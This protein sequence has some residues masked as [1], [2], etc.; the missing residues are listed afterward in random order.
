MNIYKMEKIC[1]KNNTLLTVGLISIPIITVPVI[2]SNKEKEN[3]DKFKVT[4]NQ[5]EE[6]SIILDNISLDLNNVVENTKIKFTVKAKDGFKAIV[7]N[8]ET[9]LNAENGK[10]TVVVSQATTISVEYNFDY[11]NLD[12]SNLLVNYSKDGA[13]ETQVKFADV[14]IEKDNFI[15]SL[16]GFNVNVKNIEK[17][18]TKILLTYTLTKEGLT[19][20]SQ[21]FTKE[22]SSNFFGEKINVVEN[23]LNE[24]KNAIESD[25]LETIENKKNL[26]AEALE[27]LFNEE[28]RNTYLTTS[29]E[30]DKKYDFLKFIVQIEGR[31]TVGKDTAFKPEP[32]HKMLKLFN[33]HWNGNK[34]QALELIPVFIQTI[35]H[36]EE[37]FQN[38]VT[39]VNKNFETQL[40]SF[41]RWN[42]DNSKK[43]VLPAFKK[44]AKIYQDWYGSPQNLTKEQ[45][46][47]ELDQF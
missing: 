1:L 46:K 25:N 31:T 18:D 26:Y 5:P 47:I 12:Q 39:T 37:L 28:Y 11:K 29:S 2:I 27:N 38:N 32:F 21:E 3:E 22:I 16:K 10:Y 35:K 14:S 45:L 13:T 42:T 36:I 9:I 44:M 6:G 33:Y 19:N 4:L 23:L 43:Y 8:G 34:E 40:N 17:K 20:E 15:V 7:K 41:K 30:L 24:Y